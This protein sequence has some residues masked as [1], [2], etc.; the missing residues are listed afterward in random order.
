M[1]RRSQRIQEPQQLLSDLVDRN[2]TGRVIFRNTREA[3]SGFPQ[4]Q[5]NPVAIIPR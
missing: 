2:G 5:A 1:I 4:R 3:L